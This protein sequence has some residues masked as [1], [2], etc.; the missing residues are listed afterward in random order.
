MVEGKY[1]NADHELESTVE[2]GFGKRV[3]RDH[4]GF[5]LSREGI[6]NGR[7]VSRTID[8]P[9]GQVQTISH[10]EKGQLHGQQQKFSASGQPLLELTWDH[11]V[12]HGI[13]TVYRNGHKIAT[14]PYIQGEKHGKESHFDD[15]QNLVAE[16]EWSH[17]Q[18]HGF[19]KLYSEEGQEVSWFYKGQHVSEEKFQVLHAREKAM[20]DIH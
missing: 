4:A 20:A 1:F 9:N 16:I 17:D 13:K 15:L 18:K 2:L 8:H 6:E 5:L 11:D 10:Y 12:L 7:V 19:T 14:I 3:N